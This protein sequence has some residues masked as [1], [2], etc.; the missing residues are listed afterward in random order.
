MGE[1]VEQLKLIAFDV[2]TDFEV[3]SAGDKM[4]VSLKDAKGL[5]SGTTAG[6]LLQ[7]SGSAWVK[8]AVGGAVINDIL[9]WTGSAWEFISIPSGTTAGDLLQWDGSAW[10]KLAVS[11]AAI[12]DILRWTGSAWALSQPPDS[13]SF[14]FKRTSTTGGTLTAGVLYYGGDTKA[15][16]NLPATLSGVTA[17]M[18]YWIL[19]DFSAA[20][21]TW[22][23]GANYPTLTS[24][25]KENQELWPML[26]ITCSASV[27]VSWIQRQLGNIHILR[28][29]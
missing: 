14:K 23:S 19:I 4:F 16:T 1:K 25:Q 12:D 29:D 26:E 24:T 22:A 18:K 27:I 20:T 8:L 9:R 15:I 5:P 6:D 11:G 28:R 13:Y 3:D 21:A 7:W 17:S 2:V 10:V